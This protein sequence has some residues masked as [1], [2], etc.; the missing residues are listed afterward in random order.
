MLTRISGETLLCA[1]P[2]PPADCNLPSLYEAGSLRPAKFVGRG[3]IS[4]H[5]AFGLIP[6]EDAYECR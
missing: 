5:V 6:V 4:M 1:A 2:P 3:T